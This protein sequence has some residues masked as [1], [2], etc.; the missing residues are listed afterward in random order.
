MKQI[1][2]RWMY[3]EQPIWAL[4]LTIMDKLDDIC[5]FTS[6]FSF[7]FLKIYLY[8]PQVKNLLSPR[9]IKNDS[10]NAK[11]DFCTSTKTGAIIQNTFGY[12]FWKILTN[13]S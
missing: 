12:L 1:L 4:F 13:I 2:Y 7:I 11:I 3:Q 10:K 6:I 8:P 5:E 9:L